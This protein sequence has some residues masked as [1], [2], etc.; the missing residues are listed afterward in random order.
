MRRTSSRSSVAWVRTT[1][2]GSQPG[3]DACHDWRCSAVIRLGTASRKLI[4]TAAMIDTT[5]VVEKRSILTC[6][7]APEA[8]R[9]PG[10]PAILNFYHDRA[11]W[12]VGR[13]LTGPRCSS[14][15]KAP[16]KPLES[17]A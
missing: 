13:N 1:Q 7:L 5:F 6:P 17:P 3:T 11:D 8:L 10:S 15:R 2:D 16:P 9:P 14:S 12:A 4:S